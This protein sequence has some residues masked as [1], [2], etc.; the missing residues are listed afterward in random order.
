MAFADAVKVAVDRDWGAP[1]H[2][3]DRELGPRYTQ[4][5]EHLCLCHRSGPVAT[6]AEIGG[7]GCRADRHQ[8]QAGALDSADDVNSDL[9]NTFGLL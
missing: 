6:E 9:W 4:R 1:V 7:C 2:C 8:E 5:G 3:E